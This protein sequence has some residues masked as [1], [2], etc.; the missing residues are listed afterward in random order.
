[1]HAANVCGSGPW[2]MERAG[3]LKHFGIFLHFSLDTDVTIEYNGARK[4]E[5]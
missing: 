4:S 1:L 5:V 3:S 2:G